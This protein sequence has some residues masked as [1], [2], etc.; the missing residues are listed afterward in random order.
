MPI[1]IIFLGMAVVSQSMLLRQ[2]KRTAA[3]CRPPG[4]ASMSGERMMRKACYTQRPWIARKIL[5][6]CGLPA[7]GLID[8][9]VSSTKAPKG[10]GFRVQSPCLPRNQKPSCGIPVTP[11]FSAPSVTWPVRHVT[12]SGAAWRR[13]RA[14]WLT[15]AR[16][17]RKQA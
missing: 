11:W 12:Y 13:P 5:R 17:A 3:T 15:A 10:E 6:R 2:F 7:T 4:T 14:F 9:L 1:L 16:L 8:A